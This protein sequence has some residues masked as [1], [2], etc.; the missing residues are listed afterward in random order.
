MGRLICRQAR[1][2]VHRDIPIQIGLVFPTL[3]DNV[4]NFGELEHTQFSPEYL[5]EEPVDNMEWRLRDEWSW[6]RLTR[7]GPNR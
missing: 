3:E 4:V 7:V 5:F 2:I 6:P 1:P